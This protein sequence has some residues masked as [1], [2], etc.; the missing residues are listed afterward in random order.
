MQFTKFALSAFILWAGSTTAALNSVEAP[1]TETQRFEFT[2]KPTEASSTY[3]HLYW[4]TKKEIQENIGQLGTSSIADSLAWYIMQCRYVRRNIKP[5]IFNYIALCEMAHLNPEDL[6][7]TAKQK[8]AVQRHAK[9]APWENFYI[10]LKNQ[11]NVLDEKSDEALYQ[12]LDTC[13]APMNRFVTYFT[14]KFTPEDDNFLVN[15]LGLTH[16]QLQDFWNGSCNGLAMYFIIVS[17][18][19]DQISGPRRFWNSTKALFT[20]W[21]N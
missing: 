18:I 11:L 15:N 19:K 9:K 6:E 17:Q 8:A 10:D 20:R 2:L 1:I 5:L 14:D 3:H 16:Q 7:G 13:H 21:A 4:A 12:L